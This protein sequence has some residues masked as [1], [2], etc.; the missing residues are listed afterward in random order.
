MN[1]HGPV[2]LVVRPDIR[3]IE[4]FGH[5]VIDLNGADLPL[6]PDGIAHHKIQLGAVESRFA[7]FG[8]GGHAALAG[9][10]HN[11]PLGQFPMVI[12]AEVLLFVGRVAQRD[13]GH[14]FAET[15][16]AVHKIDQINYFQKFRFQLV[17]PAE[18]MGII[19]G[20]APH[21]RQAVQLARLF[22][23]VHRTELR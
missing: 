8:D 13:L 17:G 6:A 11:G 14:K 21:P 3:Q 2:L 16:F 22:V 23:A 7:F 15:Q 20:K 5:H 10:F 19:L 4:V 18:D 9:G 1:H 12:V